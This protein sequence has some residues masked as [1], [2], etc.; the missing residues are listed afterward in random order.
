MCNSNIRWEEGCYRLSRDAT[1]YYH[2]MLPII[3]GCYRL[4]WDATDYY[5]M[6]PI[7]DEKK[8]RVDDGEHKL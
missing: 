7:G 2:G 4:L 3:M 5:R 1:D 6:L 8:Y